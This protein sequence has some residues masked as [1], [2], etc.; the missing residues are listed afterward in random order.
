MRPLQRMQGALEL[1]QA[2]FSRH[3]QQHGLGITPRQPIVLRE[4]VRHRQSA[5][6]ATHLLGGFC[7]A[8]QRLHLPGHARRRAAFENFPRA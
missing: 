5:Q 6:L 3:A 8:L 1:G 7:R 4:P 2:E